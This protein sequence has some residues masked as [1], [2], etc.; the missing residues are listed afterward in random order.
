MSNVTVSVSLF[1]GLVA[2][3]VPDFVSNLTAVIQSGALQS[4][5]ANSTATISALVE[6]LNTIANI[7]TVVDKSVMQVSRYRTLVLV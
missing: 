3:D 7:Y 2:E 4:D 5:I 1:Q 6:I